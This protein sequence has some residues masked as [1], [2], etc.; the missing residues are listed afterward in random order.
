MNSSFWD[1]WATQGSNEL[2]KKKLSI[3][4]GVFFTFL[5]ANIFLKLFVLPI[6]SWKN[7]PEKLLRNTQIVFHPELPERPKKKNSC[8]KM[9]LIDQ[10]QNVA[11]RPTVYRTG[12]PAA[13]ICA[14]LWPTSKA[15]SLSL[16]YWHITLIVS[17]VFL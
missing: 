7:H 3:S 9:W 15:W 4:E 12:V 16:I 6:K 14:I 8:S 5:K 13:L 11:Y 10:L 2:K 1:V 17:T